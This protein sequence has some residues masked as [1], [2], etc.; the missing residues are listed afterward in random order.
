MN[1]Q[2]K[3]AS[4]RR[5]WGLAILILFAIFL[6]SNLFARVRVA[7]ARREVAA[8][9]EQAAI[10][11]GFEVSKNVWREREFY[12]ELGRLAVWETET[13]SKLD[14]LYSCSNWSST[15][16]REIN[17]DG[18]SN[19]KKLMSLVKEE[20][21]N[22]ARAALNETVEEAITTLYKYAEDIQGIP[23]K[24]LVRDFYERGEFDDLTKV[25]EALEAGDGETA[26]LLEEFYI[27]RDNMLF[28][29]DIA[30]AL[31]PQ[32]LENACEGLLERALKN[33]DKSALRSL[34]DGARNFAE[35]YNVD[36]AYLS[37]AE[38]MKEKL[39]YEA[40]SDV[41]AV[42]MSTASAERT[43]LGKPTRTTFEKK[44][45]S[46]QEHVYGDMYWS[47]GGRQIF[48]AHYMDGKITK[49]YDTRTPP[50]TQFSWGSSYSK[51]SGSKYSSFDPDDHDIEAYYE[52]YQDIYE[53]YDDAYDGFLD[54]EDEW[55]NY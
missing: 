55:D 52:D 11:T 5:K 36:I 10:S 41:P 51:S 20:R 46:H 34:P 14:E 49:V 54:D 7:M 22:E 24:D 19:Q 15:R 32:L 8:M 25:I 26:Y 30:Y 33:N 45:W 44:S 18:Y 43:K 47:S 35:R 2:T 27:Y 6:C 53:D 29:M 28:P 40:K 16:S 13:A 9:A 39:D 37:E 1:T 3:K 31:E 4:R 38:S 50:K 12:Q 42:G 48:S 23:G 17:I 21:W